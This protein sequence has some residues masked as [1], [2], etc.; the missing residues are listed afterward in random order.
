MKYI[1]SISGGKDS[2][3]CLLYMLE[4]AN[5]DDVIPVFCDT[6]WEADETYEYLNYLEKR[7]NIEI[8]RLESIGMFNL[9]KKMNF[10]VNRQMRSCTLELKIK[11][12]QRWIKENIVGKEEFI[13][14][15]G[16]R[17]E[18]SDARKDT[19]CFEVKQS[20]L[21]GEKFLIPTLYPIAYWDTERVF[22]YITS[23]GIEVN[24][25][26]K[27]GF[28]RVGCMPCVNASKYEILYMPKKYRKRLE[29]L[30]NAI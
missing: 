30:E 18:E 27:K 17:R 4:R 10:I 2:T 16:I 22:E 19:E 23:K 21:A 8:I 25:L 20:V 14:V 6:K 1:V 24:P 9:C 15:E 12:F 26:Y 29:A 11:P 13:V 7:L 3:A 5:K 28:R